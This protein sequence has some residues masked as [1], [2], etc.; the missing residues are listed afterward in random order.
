[1]KRLMKVFSNGLAMWRGL[2]MTGLLR[3]VYIGECAGS[4]S[5]GRLRKRWIDIVKDCIKKRSLD[6][7]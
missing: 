2:R 6:V 5:V 3:G 7:R 1:M 4:Y